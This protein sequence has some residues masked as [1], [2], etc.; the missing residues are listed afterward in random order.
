MPA[1]PH[2]RRTMTLSPAETSARPLLLYRA[3][4]PKC[5]LLSALVVAVSLGWVLRV[6]AQSSYA[7]RLYARFGQSPG[8]L[9]LIYGGAYH[10]GRTMP[11]WTLLA[12]AENLAL[13]RWL[14]ERAGREK[15]TFGPLS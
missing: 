14:R 12:F 4:C 8:G 7:A 13:A 10:A 11:L 15:R 5:R 2:E 6:P 1:H 9:A 3:T